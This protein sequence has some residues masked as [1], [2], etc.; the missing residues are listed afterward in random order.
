MGA[1]NTSVG[2]IL[3]GFS[4]NM[5]LYGFVTYQ[6]L[7]Y[8]TTN[9]D[10]P[11]W[12][13]SL[14]AILFVIDTSQTVAQFYGAWHYVVEN[15]AN[16]S[17]LIHAIRILP[18]ISVA[19][20]LT[21]LF[22][23]VYLINRLYR[24]T[25]LFWLFFFLVFA[26]VAACLCGVIAIAWAGLTYDAAKW[27]SIIPL[28]ITWRGTEA[29]VDVAITVALSTILWRSK[30]GFTRTNTILNRCIRTSIQSGLFSSLV[31]V[32]DLVVF[33]LWPVSYLYTIPCWPLGRIYTN[34][35]LYTLLAR[36]ELAEIA[37]RTAECRDSE[38]ASFPTFAQINSIR[39]HQETV[40]DDEVVDNTVKASLGLRTVF[41]PPR[42]GV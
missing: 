6:Y 12:L 19:S 4:L 17:A 30:T 21:A 14:V 41:P 10:D 25:G 7:V 35:L 5:Y 24:L 23:Q 15:Y 1:F 42:D 13:R 37:N 38:S 16:P 26:A 2:A 29:G 22:V 33:A 36:K 39:V 28:I 3:L 31:A 20:A 9:F 34:S 32:A 18:F 27:A 40:S 11:I 8:K